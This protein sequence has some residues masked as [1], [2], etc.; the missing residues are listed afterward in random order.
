VNSAE[1]ILLEIERSKVE[2]SLPI[3]GPDRGKILDDAVKRSK[4]KRILEVGTLVGYSAIRM[5]R[6][7]PAGGSITC[8]EVNSKIAR[9]AEANFSR[10]GFS[11]LV[12]VLVG[13]AREVLPTLSGEFDMVFLD[14]AKDQYYDYLKLIEDKLHRGSFVVA[15]NAGVHASEMKDY[16]SYVRSSGNYGSEYFEPATVS[17]GYANDGVEVSVKL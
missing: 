4:A 12:R 15:D 9:T 11:D 1:A 2:Y 14:A 10:A 13:D 3:I 17:A 5:A 8:V 7:L 16:L 6:L